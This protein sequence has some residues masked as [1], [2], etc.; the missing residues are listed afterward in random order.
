M[1]RKRCFNAFLMFFEVLIPFSF[2][3]ALKFLAHT[4]A[5]SKGNKK[6]LFFG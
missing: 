6:L 4:K 1:L 2:F 3:V 5:L